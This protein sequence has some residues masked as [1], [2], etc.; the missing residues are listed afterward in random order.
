[1]GPVDALCICSL[2]SRPM[3][4]FPVDIF[5]FRHIQ[6]TAT[7][8]ASGSVASLQ[9]VHELRPVSDESLAGEQISIAYV[10]A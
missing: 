6:V 3:Y 4:H 10:N 7:D 1:M 5:P 2:H 8:L 9:K